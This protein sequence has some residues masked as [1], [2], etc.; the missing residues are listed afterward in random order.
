MLSPRGD[1][2]EQNAMS[3]LSQAPPPVVQAALI[4]FDIPFTG[5]LYLPELEG[6]CLVGNVFCDSQKRFQ[7]GRLIRTSTVQEFVESSGY[8]IA[9]T[10]SGSRYV[11]VSAAGSDV[12]TLLGGRYDSTAPHC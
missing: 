8:L 2:A 9:S 5:I 10:F 7:D 3:I 1:D 11:L 4:E 12:S 6:F